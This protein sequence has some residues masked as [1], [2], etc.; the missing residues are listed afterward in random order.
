MS[1]SMKQRLGASAEHLGTH[2]KPATGPIATVL[3]YLDAGVKL[4]LPGYSGHFAGLLGLEP[5]DV[6]LDVACGSGVF[7]RRRASHVRRVAGIDHTPIGIGLARR[8]LRQRLVDGSAQLEVADAVELPW[9]DAT[10]TAVSCNCLDCFAPGKPA[11][12]VAEMHRVLR[13]G[14][15]VVIGLEN[16]ISDPEAAIAAMHPILRPLGRLLARVF[17]GS[18]YEDPAR[19]R[20][21]EQRTGISMFTDEELIALL[22]DAG[23]TQVALPA[24]TWSR[25]ATAHRD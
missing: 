5:D 11:R 23:F 2:G 3:E 19:A 20:A 4:L 17:A 21:Y 13:P 16:S 15:R 18:R 7:L 10:F 9:P 8:L 24:G 22:E 25:F 6:Y 12:T 14:G 1:N